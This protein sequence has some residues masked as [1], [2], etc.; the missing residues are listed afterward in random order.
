MTSNDMVNINIEKLDDAEVCEISASEKL[1]D[2]F[3]EI[4]YNDCLSK[5]DSDFL[6]RMNQMQKLRKMAQKIIAGS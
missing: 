6:N 3:K 4:K 2:I 1:K 5:E